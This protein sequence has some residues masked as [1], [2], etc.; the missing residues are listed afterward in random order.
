MTK[1]KDSD[2]ASPSDREMVITLALVSPLLLILGLIM[3]IM[4][5]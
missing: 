4:A 2:T 3:G 1:D 5:G